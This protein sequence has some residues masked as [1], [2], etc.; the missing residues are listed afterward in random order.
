MTDETTDQ[1]P[2]GSDSKHPCTLCTC[3]DYIE[4]SAPGSFVCFRCGHEP[5][6]HGITI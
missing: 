2:T 4:P 5:K 3:E 1:E 6:A